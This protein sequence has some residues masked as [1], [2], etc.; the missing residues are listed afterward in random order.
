MT[1]RRPE[2]SMISASGTIVLMPSVARVFHVIVHVLMKEAEDRVQADGA[3]V[4]A[5]SN[6]SSA[7]PACCVS[8]TRMMNQ[9]R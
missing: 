5:A 2:F 1:F 7:S 6:A 9:A 8:P 3:G 4:Q